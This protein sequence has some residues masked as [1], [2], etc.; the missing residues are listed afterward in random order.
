MSDEGKYYSDYLP[1]ILGR[2]QAQS[3]YPTMPPTPEPSKRRNTM[4]QNVKGY[5]EK[6]KD[7][8]FTLGLVILVDHFLFKGALRERI[9]NTIEGAL[10][11]VEDAFHKEA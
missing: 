6:H 11:K 8:L 10:K 9:K 7:I 3:N 1:N 2:A 4:L 5:I